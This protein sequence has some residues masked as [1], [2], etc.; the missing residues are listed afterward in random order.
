MKIYGGMEVY[1][2]VFLTLALVI[3]ESGQ[4]YAPC[5]RKELPVPIV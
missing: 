5:P 2:H 1:V 4:L 3:V